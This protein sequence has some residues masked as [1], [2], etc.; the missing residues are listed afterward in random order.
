MMACQPHSLPCPP[1]SQ[2]S[3]DTHGQEFPAITMLGW[4]WQVA[5]SKD[6]AVPG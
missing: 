4:L 2:Q 3:L 6:E 1:T 5:S